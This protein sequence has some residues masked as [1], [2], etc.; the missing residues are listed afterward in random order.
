MHCR[1]LHALW[2]IS[3]LLMG[4]GCSS[5]DKEGTID[6]ASGNV[7][8]GLNDTTASLMNPKFRFRI[9]L[10]GFYGSY[11][12]SLLDTMTVSTGLSLSEL[13]K[14]HLPYN[15]ILRLE[16]PQY[17]EVPSLKNVYPGQQFAV[18]RDSTE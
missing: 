10:H 12:K 4:N 16:K 8:Q 11:P 18:L 1:F 2:L 9:Q 6:N 15:A 3:I 7:E 17:E 14:D 13:L 5:S